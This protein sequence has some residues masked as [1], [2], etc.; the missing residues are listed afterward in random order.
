MT[1]YQ[2]SATFH[3]AS[4]AGAVTRTRYPEASWR[5]SQPRPTAARLA[6]W[7]VAVLMV[8]AVTL[9]ALD[10]TMGYTFDGSANGPRPVPSYG[11]GL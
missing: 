6:R 10:L 1:T 5:L 4:M 8:L 9:A 7:V 11:L 3:P 2:H